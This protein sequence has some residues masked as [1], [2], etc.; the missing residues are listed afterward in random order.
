M[1]VSGQ[2]DRKE[3]IRRQKKTKN[4]KEKFSMNMKSLKEL[5]SR[6][7]KTIRTVV[8]VCMMMLLA[9]A[10]GRVAETIGYFRELLPG[11]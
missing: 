4:E 2:K 3:K 8:R 10:F 6:K 11:T 5:L 1:A 7:S 9:L